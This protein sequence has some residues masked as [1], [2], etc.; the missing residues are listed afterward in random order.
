MILI[1]A[2]TN[3]QIGTGHVMRCLSIAHS[4]V[5]KG[6]DVLFVTA[7]HKGDGLIMQ[8]GFVPSC[9]ESEW[10]DLEAEL[11]ALIEL[12]K[13]TQPQFLLIDSYFVTERYFECLAPFTKL[14]YMDDLNKA[15][16]DIDYLINYN[17]FAAV[18]DYS[19][20]NGTR[21]ELLLQPQY[22][23]LRAEFRGRPK[24][25]IKE[26]VTDI[27]ISAGGADPQGISV[28]LMREVCPN[29]PDV[30]FHF[31]IGAL[32]PQM[33]A[34]KKLAGGNIV[35]HINETHMAD[36]MELCDIA[37]SA[38]GSTLYEL[39]ACGTPTI[40]FTLADNQIIAAERFAREHIMLNAGD[41]RDSDSFIQNLGVYIGDLIADQKKRQLLSNRMQTLVDSCGADRIAERLLK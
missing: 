11:P 31:I 32:N 4:L 17:I 16:W 3:E 9:L 41:C 39:C 8:N 7:D 33:D 28:Q 37:V 13:S 29:W 20:Y 24:H 27:L 36:L 21:T 15:R 14:A 22:A 34:I 18:F 25:E 5:E 6:E 38:A 10:R 26:E 19:W 35:L 2:D 1:R 40:A 12:I 23:P 30:R